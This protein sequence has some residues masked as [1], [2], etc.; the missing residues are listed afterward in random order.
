MSRAIG[1]GTDSVGSRAFT[2]PR[3]NELNRIVQFIYAA[4]RPGRE[5]WPFGRRPPGR[6]GNDG[7][8][9]DVGF[10]ANTGHNGDVAG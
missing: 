6:G 4:F 5:A 2:L 1:S 10:R 7:P 9:A 3:V 8:R